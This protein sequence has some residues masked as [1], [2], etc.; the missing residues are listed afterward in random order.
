MQRQFGKWKKI[1][2]F[3]KMQYASSNPCKPFQYKKVQHDIH[4]KHNSRNYTTCMYN[5]LTTACRT[6]R[7]LI[8][9]KCTKIRWTAKWKKGMKLV[10]HAK[11]SVRRAPNRKLRSREQR[12]GWA[13]LVFFNACSNSSYFCQFYNRIHTLFNN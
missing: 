11:K 9:C 3:A 7:V 13:V 2:N 1:V 10:C 5:N 12:K 4:R 6:E 8:H